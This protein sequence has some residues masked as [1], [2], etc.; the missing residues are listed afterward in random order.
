MIVSEFINT[1]I[2]LYN[3]VHYNIYDPLCEIIYN[4][5]N[6]VGRN[7]INRSS[8]IH[9]S[10]CAFRYYYIVYSYVKNNTIY[11]R[12]YIKN[13]YGVEE[14]FKCCHIN[15]YDKFKVYSYK[16]LKDDHVYYF[17]YLIKNEW[18]N[19]DEMLN[20]MLNDTYDHI[21][22][23]ENNRQMFLSVNLMIDDETILCDISSELN[24][25]RYHFDCEDK[26]KLIYWR[27]IY[28]I[29]KNKYVNDYV[30]ND[31]KEERLKYLN[32]I[33]NLY[34]YIILNDEFLTEKI[35]LLS[36][37]MDKYIILIES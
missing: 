4:V 5:G 25:L 7:T 11:I 10:F 28:E 16:I 34:I 37:L 30:N 2:N 36:S 8:L 23:K 24:K 29:V 27:E 35:I 19:K 21:K 17:D 15:E 6:Y 13:N 9:Y 20:Y 14:R 33:R 3:Q 12:K 31:I 18:E 32:D 26:D 1:L 22:E